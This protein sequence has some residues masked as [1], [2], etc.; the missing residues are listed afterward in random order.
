M[1]PIMRAGYQRRWAL[2]QEFFRKESMTHITIHG[3]RFF[4]N[5][6]PTYKG[7]TY[8]GY[9]IEGLLLN[10]RMVQ[11]TYDDEN[12]ETRALWAYPDTG[13]WDAERNVGEF[14]E[15]LP[16]Y[17][18]QGL[19][20]VTV[21][22]QGGNPQGYRRSQPWLNSAL[23]ADGELKPHYMSRMKRILDRADELG[24]VV[25]LGVFY[26]GQD[27][28]LKDEAAVIRALDNTVTWVLQ[29]GYQN[30]LLE[31]NNEC[32]VPRYEH[33]ILMPAR[34]SELIE[35][36]KG[37]TWRGRRLLA[38]TSF[39]GGS[40]PVERVVQTSDFLLIHG[41]GV[42]DPHRIAE[43]VD[44][45]RAVPGYRPMP[46]LFNEDDHYGFDKP[47][48]NCLAAVSRGASWGY[49]DVGANNYRDGYQSP[50]VDWGLSTERKRA[51]F[52]LVREI[53]GG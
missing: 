51:F 15:A 4:I 12:P 21:N 47:Y 29:N 49:L 19:L 14:L 1:R 34:V 30:V 35:R 46:I 43:M 38:G 24:M 42:S 40:I 6:E 13:V 3:E 28:Q 22:L 17:R 18:E 7:R 39:G 37:I 31:V 9:H 8:R 48:N 16:I 2:H 23:T 27:E 33:E 52:Q 45:T 53:T 20:G 32:D 26:F 50:P 36:A 5:G 10:S 25:I 44:E 11:A 41:N